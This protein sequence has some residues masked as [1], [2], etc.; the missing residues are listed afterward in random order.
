ME[1]RLRD[2]LDDQALKAATAFASV[3]D[4]PLM[5]AQVMTA[6]ASPDASLVR[7]ATEVVLERYVVNPNLAVLT[8]SSWKLPAASPGGCCSIHSIR[9][10]SHSAWIS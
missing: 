10:G 9:N 2:H 5:R 3:A 4:G 7:A 1:R 6:L 8:F